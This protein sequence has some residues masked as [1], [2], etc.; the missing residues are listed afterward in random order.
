MRKSAA[1]PIIVLCV[2]STCAQCQS[3]QPLP[4]DAPSR[5]ELLKLFDVLEVNQ[6]V[7]AMGATMRNV[8]Q[9][10]YAQAAGSRLTLKQQEEMAKLQGELFDQ[11]V[12]SNLVQQFVDVIIP[13]YQ[14][15]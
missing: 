6:Q 5:Q 14:Q 8:M 3:V 7:E 4:T 1:V 13:I 9:Q 2:L 12:A 15:H 11:L 10:Q